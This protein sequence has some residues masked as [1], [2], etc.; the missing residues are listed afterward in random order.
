MSGNILNIGLVGMGEAA[1]TLHLPTLFRYNTKFNV[2]AGQDISSTLVEQLCM[3]YQ[4]NNGYANAEDVITDSNVDAVI[5]M[6]PDP[7]HYLHAKMAIENNKHVLL[8]KPSCL[9]L[10]HI[11]ELAELAEVNGVKVCIA[12]MRA[13]SEAFKQAEKQLTAFG[14]IKSVRVRD[15][16]R[17]GD[18]YIPQV[19]AVVTP[20]DHDRAKITELAGVELS[21]R[22]HILGNK[23]HSD[24]LW[25]IY[26]VLTGAAIHNLSALRMLIGEPKRVVSGYSNSTGDNIVLTLDYGEFFASYEILIDNL[27][28]VDAHIEV[29]SESEM[30]RVNYTTPYIRNLPTTFEYQ[31]SLNGKNIKSVSGPYYQDQF[32]NELLH[33]HAAIKQGEAVKTTL[34]DSFKDIKLVQQA[35]LC[36]A[37][38]LGVTEH[39]E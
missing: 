23:S 34:N 17:E 26:R 31:S 22:K 5:I 18:Y 9:Q 11:Q 13:Y 16:Q 33:F 14:D 38:S 1:Q 8:E 21:Q 35:L 36:I 3:Q 4:I 10:E 27:S 29:T 25:K 12:Y 2:V 6:S 19:A 15:L 28:R 30:F 32:T 39:V 37:D 24:L 7:L 20:N